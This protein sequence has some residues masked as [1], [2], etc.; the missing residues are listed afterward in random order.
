MTNQECKCELD[1]ITDIMWKGDCPLHNDN[2]NKHMTNNNWIE[3]FDELVDGDFFPFG[4]FNKDFDAESCKKFISNLLTKKDQEHKAELE[5]IKGEIDKEKEMYRS[6]F[7]RHE[8]IE[9]DN[10][11]NNGL[12]AALSILDKHINK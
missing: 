12:K 4:G 7:T 3:Q 8:W 5:M 11:Y 9:A 6:E 2:V 10:D 1:A